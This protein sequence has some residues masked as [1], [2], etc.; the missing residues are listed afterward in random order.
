M[1]GLPDSSILRKDDHIEFRLPFNDGN[2]PFLFLSTI[3]AG[4]MSWKDPRGPERRKHLYGRLG[5]EAQVHSQL[6]Q[7]TKIVNPVSGKTSRNPPLKTGDGLIMPRGPGFLSVTVA[8]CMP[9]YI[10]HRK[11]GEIMLLHSG[12]KGTG[13]LAEALLRY[14]ARERTEEIIVFLGPSIADCC[15]EV[16]RERYDLFRASF[17]E[18]AV[19]Q[20][21]GR[22]YLS[23]LQA[24]LGIA[25]ELGIKSIFH[26]NPCTCCNMEFA[27]F[28]R[29][30]PERFSS[31]LALIGYFQ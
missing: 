10:W 17:G 21:E 14:S 4:S 20:K 11:S 15:Y 18:R 1:P 24:N 31:M 8:D 26:Y 30:G 12:W 25:E 9:I 19:R 2:L 3:K 6:Q 5:I 28:R 13:I 23:L 16:D 22:F 7:H 27:S 29:Q